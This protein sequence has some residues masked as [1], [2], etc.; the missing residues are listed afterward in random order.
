MKKLLL[1]LTAFLIIGFHGKAQINIKVIDSIVQNAASTESFEGTV[2]IAENGNVAYQKSFGFKDKDKAIPI[3]NST[4][5]SIA[6]IT[7]LFTAI[8]TLQLIEE[9]RFELTDNLEGLVPEL[10]IPESTNIS[11]H[12]LLLHISGLPNENDD[13]YT[14]AKRP[15]DFVVETISN[16]SNSYGEFNYTNIDYVLLGL[17]IE[18]FDD[19]PFEHS[20][21]KRILDNCSMTQTGFLKKDN[22]PEDFA[23]SFSYGEDTTRQADPLLFIENYYAAGSMY[24][25]AGD[26]LKLDQALYDHEFLT[27]KSK[28]AMFRS[29]PKYNYSGYS[30]W[31]YN[32]PF[33]QSKP[34]VMERRGGILGAN[35]VLIRLLDTNKT[36]IILSNNNKFNPDSFGNTQSLKEALMIRIDETKR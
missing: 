16:K 6:S 13:I 1:I 12:H 22:Y 15:R 11:V 36:I 7:K 14:Q 17:I 28:E 5:F 27:E 20:V 3:E 34:K 30:V 35:S 2:L 19:V 18:K 25:T 23:Y 26:L 33:A 24:S 21:Q 9:G 8:I 29:Y 32:Y 31:T 4:S 10:K